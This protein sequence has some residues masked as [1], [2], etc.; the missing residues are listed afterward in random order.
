MFGV[1]YEG[2]HADTVLPCT[3][4]DQPHTK[5]YCSEIRLG[6]MEEHVRD[7]SLPQEFEARIC[8]APVANCND[9]NVPPFAP[10]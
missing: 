6:G 10:R 4:H 1:C 7:E 9:V 5:D 8:M 2:K 3:G